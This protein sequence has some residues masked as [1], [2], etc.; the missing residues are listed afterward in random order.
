MDITIR[1][2]AKE[3]ASLV[4]G[5]QG[6]QEKVITISGAKDQA[7]EE[8]DRLARVIKKTLLD[9]SQVNSSR[10]PPGPTSAHQKSDKTDDEEEKEE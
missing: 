5:L 7:P 4:L 1:A 6:K 8:R 2:D 3:I 10:Q 9:Q